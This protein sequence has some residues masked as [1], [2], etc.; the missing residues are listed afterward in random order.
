MFLHEKL[1]QHNFNHAAHTYLAHN[2]LQ[3]HVAGKICS[4]LATHNLE[5]S[6]MLD[7][8]SGPGTFH[9]KSTPPSIIYDISLNML[10]QSSHSHKING[11]ATALPFKDQCFD[12]II[13]N[14]MIQ[15][16]TDK[17]LVL[18]EAKRVL[19]PH[20]YIIITTLTSNSLWQ[21]Q[22]YFKHIDNNLHTLEFLSCE[23]Y[24]NIAKQSKLSLVYHQSWPETL[25]FKTLYKLFSHFKLT[26]TSLPKSTSNIGLGGRKGLTQLANLYPKTHE[27]YPL[28]YNNLLLVLQI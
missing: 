8:G 15:W 23:E 12:L 11:T 24:F 5:S 21:L 1:I 28:T 4:F 17:A 10:K 25:Y 14:L 9:S 27:D 7:L 6:F 16:S 3:Q 19:K 2:T 13:S 22:E 26:G 18:N 20:G